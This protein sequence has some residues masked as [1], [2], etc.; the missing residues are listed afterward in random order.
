MIGKTISH[1]QILG[2]TSSLFSERK[3]AAALVAYCVASGVT[4]AL[5]STPA[6]I[7]AA[8][9]AAMSINPLDISS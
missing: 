6:R 1:Y 9:G 8:S 3:L 5:R 2:A 7:R 4:S